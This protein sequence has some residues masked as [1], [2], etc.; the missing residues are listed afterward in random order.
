MILFPRN[1]R[2]AFLSRGCTIA[3]NT[4]LVYS[5]QTQAFN[6]SRFLRS[7]LKIFR[8]SIF[9]NLTCASLFYSLIA[10][11]TLGCDNHGRSLDAA[12]RR[13]MRAYAA[14]CSLLT[15]RDQTILPAAGRGKSGVT[16]YQR[17]FKFHFP[18]SLF[19]RTSRS[20]RFFPMRKYRG[21]VDAMERGME[22]DEGE[23]G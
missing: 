23:E 12:L 8:K 11:T 7:Y 1:F 3:Y 16:L 21:T 6:F 9:I 14:E 17:F 10:C 4:V 19:H 15:R 18:P 20:I 5:C 13:T 2:S 22:T